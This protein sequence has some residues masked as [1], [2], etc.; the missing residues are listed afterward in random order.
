MRGTLIA[1]SQRNHL[2]TAVLEHAVLEHALGTEDLKHALR[3]SAAVQYM[4]GINDFNRA[5]GG[6]WPEN[7]L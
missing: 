7:V 3:T 6:V 5:S 4:R 2:D 1:H